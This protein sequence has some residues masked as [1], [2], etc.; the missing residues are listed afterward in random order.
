V[1]LNPIALAIPVFFLLIGLEYLLARRQGVDVYRFNDAVTDL[2]CGIANQVV[3]IFTK[4]GTF[5]AYV[6]VWSSLSLFEL[7]TWLNWTIAILGYDLAYYWW[8][9]FTHTV[10]IGWLTHVVHHQ[11]QDY[12]LAVALRQSVTSSLSSLPFYL[13]L[14]IVGVDP[15]AF[16]ISGVISLLYQFWIH[17]ELVD[18]LGPLEWLWNTPSHHRVHHAINPQYLDKNYAA[19]WIVW[20]RM[21]GTFEPEV[22]PPVYG[23]VKPLDSFD[24]IWAQLWYFVLLVQD[25]LAARTARE[26]WQV[27]WSAPGYRP[28]GLEPYPEPVAIQ[29]DQ[30][31]KYDPK[32]P[33]GVLVYVSTH[34]ATVAIGVFAVLLLLD[35]LGYLLAALASGLI[36]WT[37]WNWGGLFERKRW[38]LPSELLRLVVL[39]AGGS[40][41]LASAGWTAVVCILV[42][43][44]ALWL[45]S[46]T[47]WLHADAEVR[48]TV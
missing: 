15:F 11:S 48:A 9:R 46:W 22:E 14:A 18:R 30:Q 32:A 5:G 43:G 13:P 3:G 1:E 41:W 2:S 20:D 39:A 8:H 40:W 27:W 29:R 7:P 44:N 45:L 38:V 28:E 19:I 23:T 31:Q 33:L 4:L 35:Q 26:R 24:P 34:F 25:T 36:L 10:N 42:A 16:A 21:F 6:W 47:R 37:T 17:T 12:N